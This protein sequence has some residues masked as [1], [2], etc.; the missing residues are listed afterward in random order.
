MYTQYYKELSPEV[1]TCQQIVCSS[2]VS[3]FPIASSDS[4][5]VAQGRQSL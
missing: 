1:R 2:C 3:A 5:A 4:P